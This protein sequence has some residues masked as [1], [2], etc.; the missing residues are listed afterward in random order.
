VNGNG[1][2][3]SGATYGAGALWA[4]ATTDADGQKSI[5]YVDKQGH[6]VLKKQQ[7]WPT[8]SEDHQ[9]WFCTYYVYDNF[10]DLRVVIP[11]LAVE[12]LVTNGWSFSTNTVMAE[13]LYFMYKYDGR[14]RMVEKRVPGKDWEFLVYDKKDR[15]VATQDGNLEEAG[16][17]LYTK[18]DALDRP[19]MTGITKNTGKR[20]EVQAE[21]DNMGNNDA[22]V[23][24]NTSR[25]RTGTTISSNKYDGFDEYV[26]V[27]SV[28]LHPGFSFKASGNKSFTARIGQTPVAATGAFPA[29]EGEILT[30]M[31][32]DNY[33]NVKAGSHSPPVG[34]GSASKRTAGLLT[35]KRVKNLVSGVFYNSAYFYDEKGQVIQTLSDHQLGGTVRAST[36]YN[37]EGKPVETLSQFTYPNQPDIKRTFS[38]NL[39]GHLER[40]IHAI[41]GVDNTLATYSYNELGEQTG[42]S[43]PE[44]EATLS[45]GYNIRGWL[46]KINE[47]GGGDPLFGMELYYQSDASNNRFN[48]NISRQVWKGRDNVARRYD[49]TYDLANRLKWANFTPGSSETH[50]Y[51]VGEIFYDGNGNILAMH[52]RNQRTP[53]SYG[54]VDF[55]EYEYK[56]GY[57]NTLIQVSDEFLSTTYTADDFIERSTTAYGYDRNGNQT[58]NLDKQIDSIAYNHINLPEEVTFTGSVGKILYDYDAEGNKLKQRVYTGSTLSSTTDYIGEFVFRNGQLDYL[59]HE[60]GRV[61]FESGDHQYEY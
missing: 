58:S 46:K 8:P 34:Y 35:G 31:Y 60:E 13:G 45:F 57:S 47:T 40:V 19:I 42:K 7:I 15:L 16:K 41:G 30:V 37:F 20:G 4:T 25:I 3:V 53:S 1:L 17:W 36:K 29:D 12:K 51:T 22:T 28:T 59:I 32:Y 14:R 11:P 26:A 54:Y 38:Y 24:A 48:G 27:S 23:N 2:P 18:Y 5:V 49:Y 44:A 39:A 55:L 21:V 61:S 56:N 9:G 10:G 6:V 33:G 43:H 50:N 52:R